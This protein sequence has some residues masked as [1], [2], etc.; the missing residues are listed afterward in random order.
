MSAFLA[1]IH[2][3]VFNKIKLFENLEEELVNTYKEKYGESIINI[4]TRNQD[5]YGKPIEDKP[6]EQLIDTSN[7]H[8]WLQN[9]IDVAETRL[10]AILTEIFNQYG[11]EAVDM[12]FQVY[13]E[14]GAH[15]GMDAKSNYSVETAPEI[16]KTLNSYLLDGMPCD[17]VNIV[18]INKD[19]RVEWE[20]TRCLHRGYW[21]SVNA[22]IDIFYKL[23][24]TWV[25]EFVSNSNDKFIYN[26]NETEINGV[27]GFIHEIIKK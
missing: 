10:S 6:I 21:E 3:W 4:V 7:I 14:H 12:A 1:P 25:R 27:S 2:T 11:N 17:I 5:K 26:V 18:T 22:D 13:S 23:R 24:N 9:R 8:G 15:S 16:Y 19:D 20:N